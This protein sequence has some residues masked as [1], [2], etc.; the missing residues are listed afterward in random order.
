MLIH[1]VITAIVGIIAALFIVSYGKWLF[2]AAVLVLT[3][4]AWQ[5]Y[6]NMLFRREIEI[7]KWL[8]LAGIVLLWG[9]AWLGNP[10]E[11]V[12][13][14]L[15]ITFAILARMVTAPASFTLRDAACTIAGVVYIGLPFA[16]LLLLRFTDQSLVIATKLGPMSA[17]AAYLWLVFAGTWAADTFAYFVGTR[18]G[19][20][21]LAPAVSP[22][23]TWEGTAGGI[24]GSC[25]GITAASGLFGL[26]LSHAAALGLVVGIVSPLGDLVESSLKRYAGVKDSGRLL[27][28][29]GG[30]LDR[31]DSVMFS[32]PAVYYYLN[33]FIVR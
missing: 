30:V 14:I 2:A 10:R 3:A 27:P 33:L 25:I 24:L 4:I 20:H 26:S 15:I 9:T 1:R 13:V 18:Y 5:E 8:G 32:A 28:G 7:A 23:K 22:G 12:A 29:H 19:K 17:G 16:H 11:T 6:C 21:K 31:F